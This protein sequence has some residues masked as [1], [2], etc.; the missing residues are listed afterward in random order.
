MSEEV[1]T[2]LADFTEQLLSGVKPEELSWAPE[3]DDLHSFQK[4]VVNLYEYGS[5]QP[6]KSSKD[7]ILSTLKKNWDTSKTEKP[8]VWKSS[9]KRKSTFAYAFAFAVI[10]AA[11]IIFPFLPSGESGLPAAAERGSIIPILMA[12]G[13]MAMIAFLIYGRG[14][15]GEN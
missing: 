7:R 11:V 5:P 3:G 1:D 6:A 2:K 10:F 13:G 12:I 8:R 14:G 9:R 4:L 15:N